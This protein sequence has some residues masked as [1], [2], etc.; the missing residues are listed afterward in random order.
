[1]TDIPV[2]ARYTR[3]LGSLALVLGVAFSQPALA[4]DQDEE[5]ADLGKITV[6]GSRIKRID[7]EGPSPVV[8]ITA[9]EMEAKGFANVSDVLDS[10]VQNTGGTADQSFTFGFIPATSAPDLRAFG[11]NAT[12]VLLD[13]RRVPVYPIPQSGVSNI[14]DFAGIPMVQVERIEILTDGASA[15]Y[16]SDAVAGVINIITRKDYDG[17]MVDLRTGD[18]A[19]GGYASERVQIFA[20]TGAGDTR[21]NGSFEYWH[22]DPLMASQRDYAGSDIANPRG[23]YSVGGASFVNDNTGEVTQAPG[24]GTPA[25]PLGGLGIPDINTPIF[26]AG[27]LWCSFNRTAFRMLFAEQKRVSSSIRIDHDLMD[28]LSVFARV[29]FTDQRTNTQLEPNFYGGALFGTTPATSNVITPQTAP[30]WGYVVPGAPNNPLNGDDCVGAG[31]VI[32]PAPCTP[33]WFVRRLVE[34]GPRSTDLQNTG[35]GVLAGLEGSF[36]SRNIYDWDIGFGY[37]KTDITVLR[38]NII[39]STFNELVSNG[40]DLF[41]PIPQSVVDSTRFMAARDA[42]SVNKTVDATIT[43]DSGLEI[44]GRPLAFAVHADF[45]AE[46]FSNIP[47]AISANGDAFD[48]GSAGSGERDRWGIGFEVAIPVLQTVNISAALRYDEFDSATTST[49]ASTASMNATSPKIGIEWRPIQDLLLRGSWGESFRAPDMQRLFGAATRAFQTVDDPVTGLQVQSVSIRAGSNPNL[50]PE[51]GTNWTVG[52]VWE[53]GN[54]M[55]SADWINIELENIVTSLSPQTILNL[56]GANQ[57]GSTCAQVHRDA[58]G[59]LQGGF[60]ESD[61]QNLSLQ[62]YAGLDLVARYRWETARA[63]TFT[64]EIAVTYVDKLET[65]RTLSDPVV[66]NTGFA[67][68]PEYRANINLG[69]ELND[70]NANVFV[71]WVDEMC[72]VQGG[73]DPQQTTCGPDQFVSENEFIDSYTLVNLNASYD[74]GNFGRLT[75]GLNNAFDEDPADDPT[76]NNWPWFFNNGGY[77]NPIG[78]E[79]TIAYNKEF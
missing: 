72:G 56:C 6:T 39:S 28:N 36:G 7:I 66:E 19:D 74:F 61:A 57:D 64:P 5:A 4:Q 71:I 2:W 48:G 46:S 34:F 31:G 20:G 55:I 21:I 49:G 38:P 73:L 52:V 9:A 8:V 50:Q 25:G 16:G 67:T 45:T 76:N 42:E 18:T 11:Q 33:G 54:F 37:N 24:C 29:S 65:Q 79:W 3:A 30:F 15:I 69:Y 23:S 35:L 41:Q 77:S 14:V 32:I 51:D 12:L 60:I 62:N 1:M 13:G 44:Q 53:P 78:Q 43:G 58:Q 27:D 47:D 22:N 68:L 70:F 75:V 40:L 17:V 26:T 59:T 10:L 63:G